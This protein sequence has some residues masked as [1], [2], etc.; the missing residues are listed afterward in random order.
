MSKR[1][2]NI[3]DNNLNIFITGDDLNIDAFPI[4]AASFV[5]LH[6]TKNLNRKQKFKYGNNQDRNRRLK[7]QHPIKICP[8]RRK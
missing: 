1:S 3:A 7:L 6:S 5:T 8:Y 4:N 2:A